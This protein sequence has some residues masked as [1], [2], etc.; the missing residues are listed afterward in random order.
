MAPGLTDIAW[1]APW[2]SPWRPLGEPLA[3][4]VSAGVSVAEALNQAAE[5]AGLS[6]RFQ[7]QTQAAGAA[8]YEQ[9]IHEHG[10]VPTRDNLH[11]FFNGLCWL[12]WPQAK[13]RLNQLHVLELNQATR[14]PADGRS[15]RGPVRDALTVF[16]ENAA[17]LQAPD[18]LWAALQERRWGDLF[19]PLRPLWGQARLLL[20]GHALHEQ[21]VRPYKAI[22][23]H[24]WRVPAA[25]DL[26]GAAL[27]A[28]LAA[29]LTPAKLA[30]K[31]FAPL[32]VLGVPGW[33]APNLNPDFYLDT[34][35][36]RPARP[37]GSRHRPVAAA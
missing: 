5:A 28:W 30:A 35:V 31:P 34:Q 24:V 6:C 32:P 26:Q 7:S 27:D 11:D 18:P 10:R 14:G 2:L 12:H 16:D 33:W 8:A 19:G 25:D 1:E 4:R 9:G 23:A 13:Q 37:L 21:L 17:L 29:D 15:L 22:T 20:F 3:A 36:F